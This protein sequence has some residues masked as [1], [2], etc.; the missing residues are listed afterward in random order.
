MA[1]Y[2]DI[3]DIIMEDELIWVVFQRAENGVGLLDPGA[4]SNTVEQGAKVELP[5]WLAQ[6]LH[7]RLVVTINVPQCFNQKTRKEIQ[8]DAVCVDLK[9]RCSYFYELGCKTAPLV[10]DRTIGS[11]L[12]Y[13]FKSRYKDVLSNAHTAAFTVAPKF[14]SILTKEEIN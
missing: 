2:Y 10:G 1:N 11:F 14:L 13:A 6:E 7:L 5:F 9:N 4:E 3:D 12:L 8:A